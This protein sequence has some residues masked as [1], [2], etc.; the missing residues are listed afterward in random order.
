MTDPAD[1]VNLDWL[2]SVDDHV[3]E[4]TSLWQH[5]IPA[6]C[7]DDAPKIVEDHDDEY[8]LYDGKRLPTVGLSVVAGTSAAYFS[9][10]PVRYRDMRPGCYDSVA[11]LDDMNRAGTLASMCFPSFPRFCGQLFWEAKDRDLALLCVRAYNDWMLDEWCASAPGRY[12]P[13]TLIPLWDPEE[14]AREV[15]RCADKSCHTIAFS[16]NPAPLGLPTLFD[17]NRYWDPVWRACEERNV[18]VCMHVGSSSVVP[19]ISADTPL[20]VNF[21]W[22]GG[23]RPSAAMLSWI[24][25][26]AFVKFPGLKIALS[27]GGIGWMPYFLQR[28]QQV[29]DRHW[30]WGSDTSIKLSHSQDADLH[31]KD[32]RIP[33]DVA[34][35]D[36]RARARE[37]VCGCFIDDEV[38]V[39]TIDFIGVDN[40]MVEVDYPHS[41]SSWPDS[42]TLM[43]KQLERLPEVDQYKIMRGT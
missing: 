8:W 37:H 23:G 39:A 14:A 28:A 9:V 34:G 42:M 22:M 30:A 35:L 15:H 32:I 18:V 38:G 29:V 36:L 17:P 16:E 3:A 6:R 43:R 7:R 2:I 33:F 25:S 24:F 1:S 21:S 11:R 12:I 4:P 26:D 20:L 13:L 27:E 40:V 41:D 31:S 10:D 5:R 19:E